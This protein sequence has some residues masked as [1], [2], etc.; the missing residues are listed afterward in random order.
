MNLCLDLHFQEESANKREINLVKEVSVFPTA[1][2]DISPQHMDT[3]V[4]LTNQ[5][6]F[7]PLALSLFLFVSSIYIKH[8][9]TTRNPPL[10]FKPEENQQVKSIPSYIYL[11][12]SNA[13][14]IN[15]FFPQY[16]PLKS[17]T[18]A[19]ISWLWF[20]LTSK[21]FGIPLILFVL[22]YVL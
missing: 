6:S 1:C 13:D 7:S 17:C 15:R 3:A 20:P 2:C 4:A 21:V 11:P 14:L 8:H 12:L 19:I 9:L 18:G 16:L 10:G 22:S 5:Y